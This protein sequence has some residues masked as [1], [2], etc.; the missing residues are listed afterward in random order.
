[1]FDK[2][3]PIQNKPPI[4]NHYIIPQYSKPKITWVELPGDLNYLHVHK[5]GILD[6]FNAQMKEPN[7]VSKYFHFK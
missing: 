6:S 3:L 5:P 7:Y 2:N 4:D 1:M